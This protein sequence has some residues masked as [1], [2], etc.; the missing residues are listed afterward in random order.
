M[1]KGDHIRVRRCGGLYSHHGIDLGDGTV[2]HF[3]GEP[4][5]QQDASI[6]RVSL[7]DFLHG[8]EL[9]VVGYGEEARSPEDVVAEALSHEGESGYDVCLNNCEHFA[10]FCKT[11]LH[12]SRQ[13]KRALKIVTGLAIMGGSAVLAAVGYKLREKTKNR[14]S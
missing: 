6:C 3:S 1:A 13:V 9:L 11:G 2:M 12:K 14:V 7:E 8:D 10:T 4:L 5:R